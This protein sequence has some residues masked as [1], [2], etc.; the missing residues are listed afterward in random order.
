MH[1]LSKT[2]QTAWP[3]D[4]FTAQE[5]TD[6][7]V[8]KVVARPTNVAGYVAG[9]IVC[10]G[11]ALVPISGIIWSMFIALVGCLGDVSCLWCWWRPLPLLTYGCA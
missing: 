3:V 6:V 7:D 8:L 1:R 4:P 11:E 9:A 5:R 10:L 2:P